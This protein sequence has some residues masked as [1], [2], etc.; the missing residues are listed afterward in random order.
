MDTG[1]VARLISNSMAGLPETLSD[2]SQS[3]I[4]ASE[5]ENTNHQR[6]NSPFRDLRF[7]RID[8]QH[9]NTPNDTSTFTSLDS[10]PD[11]SQKS[12]IGKQEISVALDQAFATFNKFVP[13]KNKLF[14]S[15]SS[16]FN[17]YNPDP[18]S[19]MV[20]NTDELEQEYQR[21]AST[22][23]VK[24]PSDRKG[25]SEYT[26]SQ[27]SGIGPTSTKHTILDDE[28][29]SESDEDFTLTH[30]QDESDS[31]EEHKDRYHKEAL[32]DV[33]G[34]QS[35][36]YQPSHNYWLG[37]LFTTLFNFPS[38]FIRKLLSNKLL[39]WAGFF[40]VIISTSAYILILNYPHLYSNLMNKE[41]FKPSGLNSHDF[42]K[43]SQRIIKLEQD[44]ILLSD[45]S[46][47]FEA[48]SNTFLAQLEEQIQVLSSSIAKIQDISETTL[49]WRVDASGDIKKLE[50]SLL[51]MEKKLTEATL[52]SWD[53]RSQNE[54]D[55]NHSVM[56][57]V[58]DLINE[59]GKKIDLLKERI[60]KLEAAKAVEKTVVDALEEYL[61]SRLAVQVDENGKISAVPEFWKYIY[62]ELLNNHS[63]SK[64]FMHQNQ[65]FI[66]EYTSDSPETH[67]PRSDGATVVTKKV[68]KELLHQELAAL[69]SETIAAMSNLEKRVGRNMETLI[70]SSDSPVDLG[71][72]TQIALSLLIKQSIQRYIS[73]TIAKVDFADPAS[74]AKVISQLTSKSYDW[75]KGLTLPDFYF[76]K[77]LDILGFGRMKVNRPTTAFSSD[78]RL[79]SCWPFNGAQGQ[80]GID[81]GR[82]VILSD[83]GLVH[84]R[85]DQ[86][87]NPASAPRTL[88]VYAFVEDST[89]RE[90]L[91]HAVNDGTMEQQEA[92]DNAKGVLN[93]S[94]RIPPEYVKIMTFEYDVY[95]GDEFQVFPVPAYIQRLN[96]AV[97]RVV[98]S[99]ENN[100][101]HED[102]TCIY[103]LRLFGEPY[104]DPDT[105]VGLER[106]GSEVKE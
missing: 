35:E 106:A 80:I 61:P 36:S 28:Y 33:A 65:K 74:G 62:A 75:K 39:L 27:T 87:P 5:S 19:S 58:T 77:F 49:A 14:Q 63:L 15:Q 37:K 59:A 96:V 88:S 81:L 18:S 79:G 70:Q 53:P 51:I 104:Y 46:N 6:C 83:V 55:S 100:W 16:T 34:L 54:H 56:N 21:I 47:A 69:R 67:S 90:K 71:N 42:G 20:L 64:E 32:E 22:E 38:L 78:V 76:H 99:F 13:G 103:R 9:F 68:F 3:T 52:D 41:I 48:T 45:K 66:E 93:S 105:L 23:T 98:F 72:G 84:V 1:H 25:Y 101:G 26:F 82:S 30:E 2:F 91:D 40:G 10:V 7:S 97:S 12:P 29:N 92:D 89:M 95:N 60:T 94:L 4:H 57:K 50:S 43:W 85:A 31:E 86:S 44:I 8:R 73:H 24:F 17:T 102:F 11:F